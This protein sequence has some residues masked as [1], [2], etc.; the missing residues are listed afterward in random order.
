MAELKD[1]IQTGLDET[2]ILVLGA[3]VLIGFQFRSVFEKGFEKLP[4]ISQTLQLVALGLMLVA[5]ALLMWPAAYHRIVEE[6]WDTTGFHRFITRAA[7][8]AL[9]PFACGIGVDLFVAG[10]QIV[11]RTAGI[12]CGAVGAIIALW[13]WYGLEWLARKR[14]VDAAEVSMERGKMG[15]ELEDDLNDRVKQVLTET[16]VVLPGAQA[17]L[18]FQ[19]ATVLVEGFGK[20]PNTAKLIHLASLGLVGL[21]TILLMTPP[22]YHR[23]VEEGCA[24]EHFHRFT[25]RTLLGAMAVLALGI[26]LD[27]GVVVLH[28][29]HSVMIAS[30][31]GAAALAIFYGLWFGYTALRRFTRQTEPDRVRDPRAAHS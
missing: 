5:V 1:K 25:S 11:G 21:A 3:Q 16:R 15:S 28:V 18:G 19:F 26:S 20:L 24:T 8:P 2:R 30:A 31:S 6:G 9:L 7:A 12:V 14:H 17:L 23:I 29:A 13:F 27:F 22:A 4:E 10:E